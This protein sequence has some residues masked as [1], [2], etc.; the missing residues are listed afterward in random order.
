M[1]LILHKEELLTARALLILSQL[2]LCNPP[3]H[4]CYI[5]G[6]QL[7]VLRILLSYQVSLLIC[8]PCSQGCIRD[9]RSTARG[10]ADTC[11]AIVRHEMWKEL[12]YCTVRFAR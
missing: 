4:G 2:E 11:Y 6:P 8:M 10:T 1:M 3:Q 9:G 12:S 5:C 7:V